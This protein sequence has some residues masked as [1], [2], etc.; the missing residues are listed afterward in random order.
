MNRF[1]GKRIVVTGAGSGIG[2]ATVIRLVEE[3]AEVFAV[4]QSS[5]GLVVTSDSAGKGVVSHALSV[6]DETAVKTLFKEIGESG[7]L[8]GIANL[9]GV[10]AATHT[11]QT[12]VEA[13]RQIIDVNLIG[14]FI[15]CREGLPLLEKSGGAIVN[16][17]STSSFFGHPFMAAY[18]ASK[19]G[20]ASMTKAIAW[21]YIKRGVRANAIAPGG[22]AT[23]MTEAIQRN[24]PDD[25]DMS[26]YMH[27][28]RPDFQVGQ[29]E[30]VASVIA[31]LLSED[32][33]FMTGEIVRIDGGVHA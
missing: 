13:F 8:H 3:G 25:V 24:F 6:T 7:D 10:L 2:R 22:I 9:A 28:S 29:P 11:D 31:M 5:D 17:A 23:A 12:S 20:I 33:A 14:T 30:Q 4:D 19:G 18:S 16:A 27:L 15:C 1:Q 26:L 32:A 21:E